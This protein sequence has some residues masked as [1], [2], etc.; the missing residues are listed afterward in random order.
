MQDGR[1]HSQPEDLGSV[2]IAGRRH[3]DRGDA[4][5]TSLLKLDAVPQDPQEIGADV[6]GDHVR[7]GKQVQ[8]AEDRV[9]RARADVQHDVA[10]RCAE[11]LEGGL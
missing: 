1:A 8:A 10:H 2:G 4:T 9:A 3:A 7:G 6:R 11:V 5:P